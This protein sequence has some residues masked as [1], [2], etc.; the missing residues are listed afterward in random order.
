[1]S[2][3]LIWIRSLN[4]G[5][6]AKERRH[7]VTSDNVPLS[8]ASSTVCSNIPTEILLNPAKLL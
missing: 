1:M 5:N 8:S 7:V 6:P 3:S 4:L 2:Q